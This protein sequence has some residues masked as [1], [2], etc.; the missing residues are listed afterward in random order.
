MAH[1][2]NL[3]PDV[4][5]LLKRKDGWFTPELAK[6][7]AYEVE[8]RLSASFNRPES[9]PT[10]RLSQMGPRCPCALWHSIHKPEEAQ[11]L[12]A[13]AE[14]K[15]AYGHIIEALAVA[16][17]KAAGHDVRGEQDTIVVDGITG[18]RDCIIDGYLVDVKSTSSFGFKKFK[19]GTIREDDSFGY[20]EQ[21]DG[22]G[23]GS[24]EDDN[25]LVKDRGFLWAIDKQLGHMCL[26]EHK[27]RE[28]HIHRCIHQAKEVVAQSSAPACTCGVIPDGKSG[29]LILDTK[30]SYNTFKFSCFPKLRTFLYSDGPRYFTRVV[31]RPESR[32]VEVD[33][34]GKIVYN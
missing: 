30:A 17:A 11:A 26:Y 23:V 29:N 22:Y 7:F 28:A 19:S 18:H 16:L 4:N 6:E 5:A 27:F 10:L 32:I 25:V 13:G 2:H 9:K 21:L 31:K 3:I 14:F 34:F 8:T 20:L 12:P 15:Y 1:I 33:K 24:L